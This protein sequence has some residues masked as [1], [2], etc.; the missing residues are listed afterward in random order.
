MIV[1]L[2]T[3]TMGTR[4]ELVLAGDDEWAL[5]SAGDAAIEEIESLNDRLSLFRNDSLV[6]HINRTA[7]ERAVRVDRPTFEL[8]RTAREVWAASGGAFDVTM[9]AVMRHWGL[10]DSA[11]GAGE[12]A[13]AWGMDGVVLDETALSVRFAR[14]GL[15]IDLG[16]I[17]KGHALDVAVAMLRESGVRAALLHA[18]TSSVAAI[19]APDDQPD[20]WRVSLGAAGRGAPVVRLRDASLSVSAHHGRTVEAEGREVGHVLDPRTGAT[21]SGSGARMAAVVAPIGRDAEAWSTALLV[22]GERPRGM[23]PGLASLIEREGS[24]WRVEGDEEAVRAAVV[25]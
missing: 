9:G 10:H 16:G 15:M 2:A 13:A 22:L 23:P 14:A 18:G 17:A 5:R 24:G 6:A 11:D 7:F 8:L 4:F 20:G 12:G 25:S 21:A 19:G 1:R 3:M